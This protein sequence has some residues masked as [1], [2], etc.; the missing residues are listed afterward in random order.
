M[1]Q[2]EHLANMTE[3][4]CEHSEVNVPNHFI[5]ASEVRLCLA[6]GNV[7]NGSDMKEEEVDR[8]ERFAE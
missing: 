2:Y 4:K 6:V 7:I 8:H 3:R 5:K 1:V